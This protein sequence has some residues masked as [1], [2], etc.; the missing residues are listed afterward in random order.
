MVFETIKQLIA[1]QFKVPESAIFEDSDI[2]NDLKFDSL[3]A[4]ELL[5][6][7]EEHFGIELLD[8]E[9]EDIKKISDII[10]LVNKKL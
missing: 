3:D 9:A 6:A 5:I 4:V 10:A 1:G 7:I 2:V 8:K